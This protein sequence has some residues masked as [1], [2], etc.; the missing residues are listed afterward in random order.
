LR[1][2]QTVLQAS[3][4]GICVEFYNSALSGH[5]VD[6]ESALLRFS[7]FSLKYDLATAIKIMFYQYFRPRPQEKSGENTDL[8]I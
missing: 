2:Y 7:W 1:L 5:T 4:V 8:F 3:L 6:F